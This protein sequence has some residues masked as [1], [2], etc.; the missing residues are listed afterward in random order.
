MCWNAKYALLILFSTAVTYV[1]GLAMEW[2][3]KQK[4][5]E[6]KIAKGKKYIVAAGFILNLGVLA[7]FKY[8]N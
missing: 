5:E 3:K 4:W 1:C 6:N 8:T 7:Y 2:C